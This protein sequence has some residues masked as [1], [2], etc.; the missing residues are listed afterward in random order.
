MVTVC[1]I[2]LL[3]QI[4]KLDSKAID[5]VLA[6]PQAKLDV[7]IWMYLPIGFQVDT[8]NES[9]CSSLSSIKA[10]IK[11]TRCTDFVITYATCPI[12]WASHLQTENALSTAKAECITIC[13]TQS[14]T[15]YDT[16]ERITSYLSSAHKQT[17]LLL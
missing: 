3:A 14:D 11:Q 15:T 7:D 6:F 1:L 13:V 12:Y 4:Y 9:K 16:Y 10:Y 8:E 2:L 17:K 5:F